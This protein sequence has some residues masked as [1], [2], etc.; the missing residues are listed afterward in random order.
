MELLEFFFDARRTS[1]QFTQVVEF[2]LPN[3]TA[4]FDF[5]TCNQWAVGLKSSLYTNPMGDFPDGKC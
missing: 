4:T 1:G 2:G 5:D 3:I